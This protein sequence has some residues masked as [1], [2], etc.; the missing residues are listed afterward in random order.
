MACRVAQGD[1]LNEVGSGVGQWV[2]QQADVLGG[3]VQKAGDSIK[4]GKIVSTVQRTCGSAAVCSRPV[5]MGGCVCGV[6]TVG[7][8]LLCCRRQSVLP[9]RNKRL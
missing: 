2:Q 4:S 7:C 3:V 8:V 9:P 1:F 5:C 6:C